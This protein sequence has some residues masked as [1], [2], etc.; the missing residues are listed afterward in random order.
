MNK[1]KVWQRTKSALFYNN[2]N[3]IAL[4]HNNTTSKNSHIQHVRKSSTVLCWAELSTCNIL[5]YR[6]IFIF[7]LICII[8]LHFTTACTPKPFFQICKEKIAPKYEMKTKIIFIIMKLKD[9]VN[10]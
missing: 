9:K 1:N 10:M 3:N 4:V 5:Q 7:G 2:N 6:T 8:F